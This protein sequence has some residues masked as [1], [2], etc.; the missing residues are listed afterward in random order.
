MSSAIR[1]RK[2]QTVNKIK[3]TF[4]ESSGVIFIDYRGLNVSEIT[5][6]RKRLRDHQ[7][8]MKIYRN[9]LTRLALNASQ[10]A[11]DPELLIG[12]TAVVSTQADFVAMAKTL[13]KFSKEYNQLKIKGGIIE[14]NIVAEQEIKA[15]AVLPPREE[16]I[17]KIVAL[18]KSP[19]TN[20]VQQVG[21]P[22]RGL[23]YALNAIKENTKG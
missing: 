14:K 12:P 4:D 7:G 11:Y 22:L 21:S 5:D 9:T 15:I 13:T 17:A 18:I 23:V 8:L 2:T 6:L 1:E 3:Q 16:L 10:P 20:F 19:I